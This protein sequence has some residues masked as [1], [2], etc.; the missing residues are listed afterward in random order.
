MTF[1]HENN[2]K[3]DSFSFNRPNKMSKEDLSNPFPHV[4]KYES[5]LDMVGFL[6]ANIRGNWNN[7]EKRIDAVI[8]L[9]LSIDLEDSAND[10]K[11]NKENIIKDGRWF[12]DWSGPY[13]FGI[14]SKR[15]KVKLGM[16]QLDILDKYFPLLTTPKHF[17]SFD[18]LK[19]VHDFRVKFMEVLK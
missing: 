17:T 3:I 16:M 19:E 6:T 10:I 12:R 11:T 13:Y 1:L 5:S 7:C 2:L 14:S 4:E 15:A 9:L 18:T 8:D